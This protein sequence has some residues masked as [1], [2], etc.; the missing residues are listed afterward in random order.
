MNIA[1]ETTILVFSGLV[2]NYPLSI[3]VTWMLLSVLD[4]TNPLIFATIQTFIFTIV[5]WTRIYIIRS[6]VEKKK[7]QTKLT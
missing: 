1:K 7:Q 5:S 3:G 2:I 4:I 6:K